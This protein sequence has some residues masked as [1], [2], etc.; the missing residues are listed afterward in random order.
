MKKFT[1]FLVIAGLLV[2]GQSF[3][4]SSSTMECEVLQFLNEE[5]KN[6]QLNLERLWSLHQEQLQVKELRERL[7]R[8]EDT[9]EI[10]MLAEA[11]DQEAEIL[12]SQK[13]PLATGIMVS[14]GALILSSLVI[15]RINKDVAGQGFKALLSS[16]FSLKLPPDAKPTFFDKTRW[17]KHGINAGITLSVVATVAMSYKLVQTFNHASE[18]RELLERLSKLRDLS[19]QIITVREKIESDQIEIASK[20]DQLVA[21]GQLKIKNGEFI[22]Q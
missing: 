10:L 1:L 4:Q 12:D 15:K 13:I 6:D 7:I 16:Q 11:L 2:N 3:A 20:A 14:S 5:L 18:L 17:M 22:C 21:N 9:R 19:S 8:G